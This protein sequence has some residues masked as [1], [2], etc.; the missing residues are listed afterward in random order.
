[1]KSIGARPRIFVCTNARSPG[2][3]L[4]AGCGDA[5]IAVHAAVL[6]ELGRRRAYG[7]AW[8]AKT[9]CL[10]RCPRVGCTV[11]VTPSGATHDEVT[12]V[13]AP[14]LVDAALGALRGNG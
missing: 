4:G 3:P 13:D 1:M 8:L 10:G 9:G 14:T 6:A 12:P 11:V 2:D 5:G 7:A